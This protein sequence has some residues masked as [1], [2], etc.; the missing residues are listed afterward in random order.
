ML[1]TMI[2]SVKC[3]GQTQ[4]E[5]Y[6]YLKEIGC[7]HPEIVLIQARHETGNFKSYGSRVRHNLFGLWNSSEKKY[8]NFSCWQESCNA[9]LCKVQYKYTGGDY[10]SFLEEVG[11]ATDS[12]YIKK[13]KKY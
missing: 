6:S 13:L 3:M 7:E 1:T 8:Y 4:E 11:Y 2:L 5:V 9:Y 10:Y 12:L